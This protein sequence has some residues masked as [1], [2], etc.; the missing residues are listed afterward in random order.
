[1]SLSDTAEYWNDVKRNNNRSKL[2]FTH[3]IGLDCGYYHVCDTKNLA[4]IDCY[5][6][7]KLLSKD[8]VR[9]RERIKKERSKNRKKRY[10]KSPNEY[11][12]PENRIISWGKYL[13]KKFGEVPISYLYWFVKNAYPQMKD[14]KR[15]AKE[16]ILRREEILRG[17][18][19]D[20]SNNKKR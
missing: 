5:A 12:K 20:G 8:Q 11:R 1:M 15:W 7:I 19:D 6:C 16:E 18:E 9:E 4:D 13:G 2:P 3:L 17:E 10:S 14:K